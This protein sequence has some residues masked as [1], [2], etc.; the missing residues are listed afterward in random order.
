MCTLP[1]ALTALGRRLPTQTEFEDAAFVRKDLSVEIPLL[2]LDLHRAKVERRIRPL[3]AN[4]PIN[5]ATLTI[6]PGLLPPLVPGDP[7]KVDEVTQLVDAVS[8]TADASRVG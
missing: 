8:K 4:E 6:D 2:D 1:A 3:T 7:P 5:P